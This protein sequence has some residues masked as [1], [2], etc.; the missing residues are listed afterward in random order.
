MVSIDK[1]KFHIHLTDEGIMH[2][3]IKACE[4]FTL[5]DIKLVLECVK[6]IGE[7]PKYPNLIT[8]DS[9]IT[10]T[11]EAREFAASAESNIY[12]ICDAFVVK[13]TALKLLGNFYLS[14]NKPAV[15]TQLFEDVES[16]KK[17]LVTFLQ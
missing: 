5:D 13:K 2:Y 6:E 1:E 17:W 4:E 16:A 12:T 9:Y 15:P 10:T 11:S 7:S 8:F 3:H 14:M